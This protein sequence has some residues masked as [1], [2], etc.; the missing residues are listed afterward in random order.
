MVLLLLLHPTFQP[1]LIY[2]KWPQ[3]VTKIYSN[4]TLHCQYTWV[5][6]FHKSDDL[7]LHFAGQKA[8]F[9]EILYSQWPFILSSL[10][11]S[12]WFIC[13]TATYLFSICAKYYSRHKILSDEQNRH[14]FQ[15]DIKWQIVLW[16]HYLKLW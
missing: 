4:I 14:N 2:F 8:T 9:S 5:T 11:S 1:C 10:F 13:S 7:Q 15:C 12:S 6:K 3:Y 16:E